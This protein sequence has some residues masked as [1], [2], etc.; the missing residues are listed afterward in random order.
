[1]NAFDILGQ[2]N[3]YEILRLMQIT[4]GAKAIL[5]VG[6]CFGQTLRLLSMVCRDGAR[7]RSVDLGVGVENM[8]GLDTGSVLRGAINDLR[9]QG[10][11]A[12]VLF[13]DSKSLEAS[14]FAAA[15]GP[16]DLVLIDG[17]HS[18]EGAKADWER[19]GPMGR[20]VAFHDIAHPG[21]GV[22]RLWGEIRPEH[23]TL[24]FVHSQMGIG[25]V[26]K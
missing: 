16:Y 13:G 15:G 6:S 17:D 21:H 26:L 2:Q 11:D 9:E 19:Y 24:E 10:F 12:E 8:A 23:R 3:A 1:M 4:R 5:E 18:Y 22:G 14:A 25:V 7:I 20:M